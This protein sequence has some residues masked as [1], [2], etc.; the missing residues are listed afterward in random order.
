MKRIAVDLDSTLNLLDDEWTATLSREFNY[1]VTRDDMKNWDA[2]TWAPPGCTDVFEPLTRPG[3]F[4]NLGIQPHAKEVMQFLSEHY[5]LFIAT[6]YDPLNCVEKVEWVKHHLPMVDAK[7]V[8][9]INPKYLLNTDYLIDDGG[10]NV[11]PFQQKAI[12]FDAPWNQYIGDRFPRVKN[13][14]EIKSYFEEQ[15]F[16]DDVVK[17]VL[18][19]NDGVPRKL[20]IVY[21]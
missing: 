14:L 20:H 16:L 7:N 21:K 2:T 10:H 12:L 17:K 1:K 15:L 19:Q 18:V 4:R 5:E 13:W 6:A 8:I 3:F 11:E 9:F